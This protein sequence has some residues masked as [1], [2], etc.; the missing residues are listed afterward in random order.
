MAFSNWQSNFDH[1]FS[2]LDDAWNL[3]IV[4]NIV[5]EPGWL[6]TQF[7]GTATFECS[8]TTCTNRW[9]SVNAG[10]IIHYRQVTCPN[11][12]RHGKVKLFLG[13]QKCKKCSNDCNVFE[14]AQWNDSEIARA[15]TKV[16]NKVKQKFYNLNAISSTSTIENAYIV[17]DRAGPHETCLCQLCALRVCQYDRQKDI[18]SIASGLEDLDFGEYDDDYSTSNSG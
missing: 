14:V 9:M 5:Q 10:A 13:G 11:G 3:E 6:Q 4:S 2:E 15:I 16:L 12:E 8:K 18:E 7:K 17:G 1:L